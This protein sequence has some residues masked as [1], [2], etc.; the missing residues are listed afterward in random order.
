MSTEEPPITGQLRRCDRRAQALCIV[1]TIACLLG[2]ALL[3]AM[4]TDKSEV[5][6]TML[7]VVMMV[8]FLSAVALCIQLALVIGDVADAA[9]RRRL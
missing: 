7:A 1:Q 4:A 9:E 5:V 2:V 8:A 6:V 3:W